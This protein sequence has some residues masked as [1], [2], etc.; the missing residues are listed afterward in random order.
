MLLWDAD[1]EMTIQM[2]TVMVP[3]VFFLKMSF[4]QMLLHVMWWET[5][6]RMFRKSRVLSGM[7]SSQ[8]EWTSGNFHSFVERLWKCRICIVLYILEAL[9]MKIIKDS[10][11]YS[12]VRQAWNCLLYCTGV[13]RHLAWALEQ[14]I[15]YLVLIHPKNKWD[16]FNTQKS[17]L[18][19]GL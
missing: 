11:R 1:V 10:C 14:D 19:M 6:A 3:I 13:S 9:K 12:G 7:Y 2:V 8:M 17:I 5:V 16:T 4:D 15:Y 18:F